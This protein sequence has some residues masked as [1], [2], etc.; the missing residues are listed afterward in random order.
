MTPTE[1][2]TLQ[3][4]L[5]KSESEK[6]SEAETRHLLKLSAKRANE[7]SGEETAAQFTDLV[8][9]RGGY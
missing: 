2:T 7:L 4:L 8:P 6:L 5:K 9:I 1:E 3:A